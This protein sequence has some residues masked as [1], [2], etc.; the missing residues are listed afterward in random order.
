MQLSVSMAHSEYFSA[1]VTGSHAQGAI[2]GARSTCK[3]MIRTERCY[4]VFT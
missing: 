3:S 4:L 1:L 2:D